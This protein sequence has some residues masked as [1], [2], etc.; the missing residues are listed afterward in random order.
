MAEKAIVRFRSQLRLM[1]EAQFDARFFELVQKHNRI[2]HV[3]RDAVES[4]GVADW[5]ITRHRSLPDRLD[6]PL[7]AAKEGAR[8]EHLDAPVAGRAQQR[9]VATD[10]DAAVT[11]DGAG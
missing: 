10:D 6:N 4:D 1:N 3:T 8:R 7:Y 5:R 2:V 9:L 11:G